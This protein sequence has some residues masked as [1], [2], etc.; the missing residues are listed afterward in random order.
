MLLPGFIGPGYTL[1][2]IVAD[3]QRC[4]NWYPEMNELRTQADG[5]QTSLI[6]VPGL[7]KLATIGQGPI[8]GVHMTSA[9]K[10]AVVSGSGVYRVNPDYSYSLAG[11]LLTLTGLVSM[12]DNGSQ[13]V[14]VDGPYGYTISLV[15]GTMLQIGDD[16][17]AGGTAVVFQDGYFITNAPGTGQ[18]NISGLYNGQA[19]NGLDMGV[20]EGSPDNLVVA[21]SN[22]R[23]L[24][25]LGAETTEVWWDS[26]DANFPFTRIDGAYIEFGCAAAHTAKKLNNSVVWLGGGS[27]ANGIVWMSQGFVPRR[28]SNHA[29]EYAISQAG[30][31]STASA[32]TYQDSG[33]QFYCLNLPS[34]STTWVYDT[35]T[36]Q[37]SERVYNGRI[38]LERHRASC[39]AWAFNT[40]VVGD[41]QNG[42]I[43]ALDRQKATDDGT[44]LIRF[45]SAPHLS[46]AMNRVFYSE[47]QLSMSAGIGLDGL[48]VDGNGLGV[49]PQIGLSWS[50]DYGRSWSPER[51]MPVGGIGAFKTRLL[52]WKLGQSRN[53]VFRVKL[54]DPIVATLLAA[55]IKIL[56]GKS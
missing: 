56:A 41:Y 14:I 24:W 35:A 18:F 29:V 45:R 47:F 44:P 19:W 9:G 52:W 53:R 46:D 22:Q 33:H 39:Y 1:Q 48:G 17:F 37:W 12:A 51:M 23:Q 32:W 5:E 40:H 43:Y 54:S 27:K 21:V 4:V 3:C 50:D 10:L 6:Q 7:R 36:N 11:N 2:S 42:N 25:L 31:L 26:G 20:A 55:D 8:R 16:G 38:G 13:L 30:D 34:A 49:I 15:D 28:L